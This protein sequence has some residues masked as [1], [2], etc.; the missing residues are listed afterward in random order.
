MAPIDAPLFGAGA[1]VRCQPTSVASSRSI[2]HLSDG[3]RPPSVVRSAV[4]RHCRTAAG[5]R[6][7][8]RTWWRSY[9][10]DHWRSRS[11]YTFQARRPQWLYGPTSIPLPLFVLQVR[12]VGRGAD[13]RIPEVCGAYGGGMSGVSTWAGRWGPR[14]TVVVPPKIFAGRSRGSSWRKGPH[15][16]SSFLKFDNCRPEV[17]PPHS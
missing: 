5:R 17:T 12:H 9:S 7:G 2:L 6:S 4:I 10:T 3:P 8:Y 13:C 14:C 1:M 16:L 15:P 11:S